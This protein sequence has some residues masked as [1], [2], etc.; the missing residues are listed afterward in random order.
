LYTKLKRVDENDVFR[1]FARLE[2][3][4]ED[5]I[6]HY[7]IAKKYYTIDTIEGYNNYKK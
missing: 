2:N 3:I 7:Y 1:N 4:S 6:V 5:P